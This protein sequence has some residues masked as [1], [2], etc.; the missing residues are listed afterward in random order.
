MR[1]ARKNICERLT[2]PS[3]SAPAGG[4]D[5]RWRTKMGGGGRSRPWP[6]GISFL[7]IAIGLCRVNPVLGRGAG[8]APDLTACALDWGHFSPEVAAGPVLHAL[9]TFF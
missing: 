4:P 9:R 3:S 6:P 7:P 5:D 2:N 8:I 1:S